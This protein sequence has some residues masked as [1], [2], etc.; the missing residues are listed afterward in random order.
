MKDAPLAP[1]SVEAFRKMAKGALRKRLK[2]VRSALPIASVAM[3]SARIVARL[4]E[5]AWVQASR[6]VALYAAMPDRREVDVSA[7]HEWL[8][9]RQVRLYYPF[10]TKIEGGHD[11]GFRLLAP[12]E[13]LVIRDNRFAEPKSDAPRARR[14]DIDVVIVPA[15][16][17]SLDG[18]RVGMGSGFYDVTL[19]DVCPPAKSIAVAYDFQRMVEV[20][21][22]PHDFRCDAV[23]TDAVD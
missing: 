5:H 3:R 20:P 18:Y 19:P 22:E 23:I 15:V 12:G 4:E 10:M 21:C 13:T 16:A 2:A 9:A 8:A 1:D 14:G 6:G 17:V 7:L 11:T